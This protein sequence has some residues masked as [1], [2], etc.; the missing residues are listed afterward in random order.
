MQKPKIMS[1]SMQ[2]PKLRVAMLLAAA[3]TLAACQ[4]KPAFLSSGNQPDGQMTTGSTNPPEASFKRTEQLQEQWNA[5][6]GDRAIGLD[7]AENLGALGQTDKQLEVLQSVADKNPQDAAALEAAG[8][9]SLTAGKLDAATG[10]LEKASHL[11]SMRWQTLNALG[12]AYDQQGRHSL[13]RE[14]YAKALA[15]NPGDASIQNNMAMSFSLEGK[16]PEAEKTL[17]T[18]MASPSASNMPRIRQNL[19]LVVGLQGR[20]DEARKIA[21][22]DLPPDQVEANLAY[23]QQMLQQP[24]TW[25]QLTPDGS[26]PPDTNG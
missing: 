21:S 12:S 4:N 16:L 24:N 8:K 15:M 10:Y 2:L 11:P 3:L 17:R 23:L 5:K 26:A 20:F 19:A 13:A 9:Q 22:E 6:P 18:A 14:S 25:Q 1:K 7:Y